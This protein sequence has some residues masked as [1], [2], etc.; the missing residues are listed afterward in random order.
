MSRED[1][2]SCNFQNFADF[3]WPA[4][5]GV[6][7]ISGR[8]GQG[9]DTTAIEIKRHTLNVPRLKIHT[10]HLA[11]PLKDIV[12]N[13][14]NRPSLSDKE[15]IEALTGVT[16]RY[17]MQTLGTE[18]GRDIINPH[19]WT[20]CM[21]NVMLRLSYNNYRN[22]FF[23]PDVRFENELNH[24]RKAKFFRHVHVYGRET[25]QID[26]HTSEALENIADERSIGIKNDGS[27]LNLQILIKHAYQDAIKHALKAPW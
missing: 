12:A 19:I 9:K 8:K 27:F 17:I 11:Q 3:E 23:V 22:L 15:S 25:D 24:L 18:W 1:S 20:M 16:Y 5:I 13:L 14:F 21:T 26:T 10:C 4:R 2:L 7:A 6:I